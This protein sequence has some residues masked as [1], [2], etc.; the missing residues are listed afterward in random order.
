M[1]YLGD[2]IRKEGLGSYGPALALLEKEFTLNLETLDSCHLLARETRN[3]IL[4]TQNWMV[5]GREGQKLGGRL[6]G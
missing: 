6:G 1:Y 4:K 3:Y 2:K 5:G